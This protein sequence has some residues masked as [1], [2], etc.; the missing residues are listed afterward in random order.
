[1]RKPPDIFSQV[2]EIETRYKKLK[3]RASRI[4]PTDKKRRAGLSKQIEAAQADLASL[5]ATVKARLCLPKWPRKSYSYDLWTET[6][7]LRRSKYE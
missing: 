5:S 6:N 4:S 3:H 7:L 1:M 2:S